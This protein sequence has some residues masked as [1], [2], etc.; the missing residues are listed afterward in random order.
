MART[1]SPSTAARPAN[2]TRGSPATVR[3]W[4]ARGAR[5][6]MRIS[7]CRPTTT[8]TAKPTRPSTAR[9]PATGSCSGRR[10]ARC[11]TWPWGAPAIRRRAGA[12]RLRR[13]RQGRYRGLPCGHRPVVHHPFDAGFLGACGG[14]RRYADVPV[15]GDYD[16]DGK[17]DIAIYRGTTGEWFVLRSSNGTLLTLAWGA[18]SFGDIPVPADY[19]GDGQTDMAVYRADHGQWFIA[20]SGGGTTSTTFGHPPLADLPVA[21][22]YDGDGKADLAIY[23][24]A[25]GEWFILRSSTVRCSITIGGRRGSAIPSG[26]SDWCRCGVPTGHSVGARTIGQRRR[27]RR[28]DGIRTGRAMICRHA[29][30][31]HSL[32]LAALVKCRPLAESWNCYPAPIGAFERAAVPPAG[33]A[34]P[35]GTSADAARSSCACP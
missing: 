8:V 14:R 31:N 11:C 29:S 32:R 9:P 28:E 26:P 35:S 19:D 18:S 10:M 33:R 12:G 34:A 6:R 15:P 20:K 7:R 2:G 3:C 30:G 21:G 13:R 24:F 23:R 22:D 17:A 1:T 16:G 25:T 4:P 27:R 5:P